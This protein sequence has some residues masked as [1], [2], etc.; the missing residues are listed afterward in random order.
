MSSAGKE[1]AVVIVR[2]VTTV[3]GIAHPNKMITLPYMVISALTTISCLYTSEDH[4][5]GALSMHE[6]N[7]GI[8][9][10]SERNAMA[11]ESRVN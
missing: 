1:T 2:Y 9:W 5:K 8:K 3:G 6:S 7:Q 4:Q 11:R 10:V